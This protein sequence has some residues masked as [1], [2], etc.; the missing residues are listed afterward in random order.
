MAVVVGIPH[1]L[2][3]TATM[4]IEVDATGRSCRRAQARITA[5][6]NL[7]VTHKRA[8]ESPRVE[9]P[10]HRQMR[11]THVPSPEERVRTVRPP[12]VMRGGRGRGREVDRP[13]GEM[14]VGGPVVV[15]VDEAVTEITD[16]GMMISV[17]N[18][19]HPFL[20][21]RRD[22]R[23]VVRSLVLVLV[24]AYPPAGQHQDRR[25]NRSI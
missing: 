1:R 9:R 2:M 24:P 7:F 3:G 11:D 18:P 22:N 13:I 14:A 6:S 16:R 19:A 15:V 4:A 17:E 10:R 8:S 25:S 21:H 23:R 5:G 20:Q 12:V